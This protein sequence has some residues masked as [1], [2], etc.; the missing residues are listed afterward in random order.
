MVLCVPII[1]IRLTN[2]HKEGTMT[3]A[4]ILDAEAC[5]RSDTTLQMAQLSDEHRI[6][7]QELDDMRERLRRSFARNAAARALAGTKKELVCAI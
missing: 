3:V 5:R 1:R 6:S 4:Q 7:P 2:T